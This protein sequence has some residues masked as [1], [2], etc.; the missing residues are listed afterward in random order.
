MLHPRH[1]IRVK[2][3]VDHMEALIKIIKEYDLTYGE[4]FTILSSSITRW[5]GYLKIDEDK[6]T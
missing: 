6:T 1:E 2:A 5:A 4:I 3:E